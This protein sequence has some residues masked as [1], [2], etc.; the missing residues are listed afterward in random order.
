MIGDSDRLTSVFNEAIAAVVSRSG[1][2]S[3]LHLWHSQE[4]GVAIISTG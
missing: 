1:Q 3:E 4:E 2:S